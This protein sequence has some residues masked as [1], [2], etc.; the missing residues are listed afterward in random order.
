MDELKLAKVIHIY[1]S[2]SSMEL[3][4]YIPIS[5]LNTFSKIYENI[6]YNK[7]IKFLDRYDILYE[8]QFAFRQ[9]HS[10]HHALITIVDKRPKHLDYGDNG[11]GIFIGLNKGI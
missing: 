10:S 9:K 5:V 4:N 11:F 3:H 2:G 1:K 8:N 7:L 6:R